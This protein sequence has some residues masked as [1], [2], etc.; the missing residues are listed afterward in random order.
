[1]RDKI[2]DVLSKLQSVNLEFEQASQDSKD[3]ADSRFTKYN[4]V[5]ENT[6]AQIQ[7]CMDMCAGIREKVGDQLQKPGESQE[8]LE[9][10]DLMLDLLMKQTL[11]SV[12]SAFNRGLVL[13]E[14]V[15][16]AASSA[17]EINEAIRTTRNEV[18]ALMRQVANAE[19]EVKDLGESV[20][21]ERLSHQ[22]EIQNIIS[23]LAVLKEDNIR[24]QK[25]IVELEEHERQSQTL[26]LQFE[27]LNNQELALTRKFEK[28]K[29]QIQE[30]ETKTDVLRQELQDEIHLWK[31]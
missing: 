4:A 6:T 14:D 3:Q 31:T 27:N 2:L 23:H 11:Y 25:T 15:A 29:N 10:R 1:M 24:M 16:I 5:Q 30:S 7:S 9:T 12:E 20:E 26:K 8:L 22:G 18:D 28:I 13:S 17:L 21:T 19:R